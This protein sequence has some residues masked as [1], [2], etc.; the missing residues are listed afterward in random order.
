MDKIGL[1]RHQPYDTKPDLQ[2]GRVADSTRRD[3]RFRLARMVLQRVR[4][5]S[6]QP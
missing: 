4:L 1:I 3:C 2:S 5:I 6:I